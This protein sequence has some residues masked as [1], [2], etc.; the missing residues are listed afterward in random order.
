MNEYYILSCDGGGTR[1][2]ITASFLKKMEEEL[3]IK[4][5]DKFDM[6]AGTSIGGLN[7]CSLGVLGDT[8]QKLQ[9]YYTLKNFKLLMNKSIVDK[10]LGLVQPWP[11]Y[12]GKGKTHMLKEIFG[13]VCIEESKKDVIIPTYDIGN[14]MAYVYTPF[15][16][17]QSTQSTQTTLW[18]ILDATSAAPAY[19]PPVKINERW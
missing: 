12:D 3:N 14:R 10:T 17:T 13:N 4:C 7:A 18:E 8:A 9:E 16:E 15:S 1:G 5:C 6:F 11:K 2:L 19:Y